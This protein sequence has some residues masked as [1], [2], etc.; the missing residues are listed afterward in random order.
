MPS[1]PPRP[2]GRAGPA[3]HRHQ[4][5][6]CRPHL[7]RRSLWLGPAEVAEVGRPHGHQHEPRA[8]LGDAVVGRLQQPPPGRV[9][10]FRQAVEHPLPVGG[11]ARHRQPAHVLEQ[12]RP[13]PDDPAQLDRPGEQVTLVGR[14]ELPAGHGERRAGH[15][16]REQVGAGV[17]G[18]PP[19]RR[20]GDVA[21]GDLPVRPVVTEGG[22]RIGV[23][24]DRQLVLEARELQLEGLAARA[25]ADLRHPEHHAQH[26]AAKAP[27]GGGS[28]ADA[29]P[30]RR[31]RRTLAPGQTILSSS[32]R[33]RPGTSSRSSVLSSTGS[34]SATRRSS[35]R[36]TRS[37]SSS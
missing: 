17:L 35:R 32:A 31:A 8:Q 9:A 18:R 26:H 34:S 11:E 12:Q 3:V 22:A 1:A 14:A 15:A 4:R 30:E 6:Q 23:Q 19:H 27:S 13:R 5:Q 25:R 36:M 10:E 16:A 24:F 29:A 2:G 7:G 20:A 33:G 37:A 21:L 28:L